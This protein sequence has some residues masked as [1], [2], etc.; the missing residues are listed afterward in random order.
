MSKHRRTLAT[1]SLVLLAIASSKASVA[2][3]ELYDDFNSKRI[4]P[5]KWIGEPSSPAG[6]DIDRREVSVELVGEG[7]RRL[8]LLQTVYSRTTHDNGM[9]GS[10][11]GLGFAEPSKV[12]AVSFTLAVNRDTSLGCANSTA[13]GDAGFFG[14]YFNPTGGQD[15]QTGD[16]VAS[17]GISRF[18]TDSGTSLDVNGSVS[19]CADSKCNNQTTLSF[20]DFG[21]APLGSTNK[22]SVMWDQPNHQ[23][24]FRVNNNPPVPVK[25]TVPDGFSP[26]LADRSFF[27]F[28]SVPHCTTS[29][30]RSHPSTLSSMMYMSIPSFRSRRHYDIY[31]RVS[32]VAARRCS[33]RE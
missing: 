12:T 23:F 17:I 6:S 8:H 31:T 9:G 24:V 25:Y 15:G 29:P 18:S 27:V 2:Q 5:S 33:W 1:W 32:S 16:I 7:N 21:P 3:L 26:G 30:D 14:D 22:L 4:D 10:G 19:Q 20:E 11:F 28:G 13:F